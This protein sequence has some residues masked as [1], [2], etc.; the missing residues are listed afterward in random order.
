MRQVRERA[1]ARET[2]SRVAAAALVRPLLA[3]FGV[4]LGSFVTA[5]GEVRTEL[6]L[7]RVGAAELLR[8]AAAAEPDPVRCA[9]PEASARMV[10]AIDA[11]RVERQTLG[12]SFVVFATGVPIGLGSYTHWDHRLDGR[13]AGA[14]CS[15][16]AVK[17]VEVGPA[18]EVASLPGGEAQD[19]IIKDEKGMH[20]TSNFAGGLE[21]GMT[22]GEPLVI[23]AAMKP[24]SSIRAE[25]LSVD[26]LTGE[27]ADPA[28]VRSDICAVPA[29][30]VVGEA[31]V[32]WILA[33]EV[34]LRFGGDRIDAMRAAA[35]RVSRAPWDGA[36]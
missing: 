12:G 20:R 9:E 25:S 31:M 27:P 2:A 5:I 26:L 22:N 14:V 28:Y 11:A 32:A 6:H 3:A 29:A 17:G 13:L 8:L 10:A 4:T 21:G 23:R 34:V 18:S 33:E 16:P 1:S 19:P 35:E 36:L 24:L 15:I 30:A 7:A